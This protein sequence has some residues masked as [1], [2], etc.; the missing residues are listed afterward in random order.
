MGAALKAKRIEIWTDVEGMMTTD[1]RLCG[2]ARRIDVIGFDEASEMA[3]FGAKVLHPSTLIPAVRKNIPVYVLNSRRPESRGTCIRAR[4]PRS[5]TTFRAIAAKAGMKVINVRSPRRLG[6]NGFLR[7]VFE[8]LERHGCAADLV[9]TSEVSVSIALSFSQAVDAL[10]GDLKKLGDVEVE[11]CKAIVC[12]VGKHIRGQVGI[13][14]CVFDTLAAA[15][16][17][18]HMISQG[19]SEI[20]IG[21]VIEERDVPEA[22]R[23]LHQRFFEAKKRGCA[24]VQVIRRKVKLPLPTENA[25]ARAEVG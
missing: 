2:D 14:A 17:N 23:Q 3:Y 16:I 5:R 11:D 7:A 21:F 19:A 1:P 12:L 8:T 20:N 13:A 15:N 24:D 4:A 25:P 22:V 6:A 18:V 9:S 10:V